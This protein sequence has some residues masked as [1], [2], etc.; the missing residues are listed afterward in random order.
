MR[1]I[2]LAVSLIG[3]LALFITQMLT[4]GFAGPSGGGASPVFVVQ[5]VITLIILLSALYVI[6]VKK[7]PDDGTKNWAFGALGSIVGFWL[8]G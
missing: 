8:K 4:L 3:V 7:A 5:V 1:K 2:F 6:L